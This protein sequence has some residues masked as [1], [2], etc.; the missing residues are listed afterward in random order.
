MYI[1]RRI[2]PRNTRMQKE[3]RSGLRPWYVSRLYSDFP[4]K[5]RVGGLGNIQAESAISYGQLEPL[6]S[7]D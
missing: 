5:A 6:L 2:R 7:P 1:L 4:V 3:L